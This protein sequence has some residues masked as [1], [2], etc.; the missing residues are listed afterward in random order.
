MGIQSM[1]QMSW[2]NCSKLSL[3]EVIFLSYDTMKKVPSKA[4]DKVYNLEDHT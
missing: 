1:R 2:L 3:G 4:I